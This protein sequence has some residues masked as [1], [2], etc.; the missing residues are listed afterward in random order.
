MSG[1]L[2][3]G[4]I[5]DGVLCCLLMTSYAFSTVYLSSLGI[6]LNGLKNSGT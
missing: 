2:E 4:F 1:V 3:H 5:S 6:L